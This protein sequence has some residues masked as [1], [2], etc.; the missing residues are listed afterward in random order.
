MDASF[1]G[2]LQIVVCTLGNPLAGQ[3][4]IAKTDGTDSPCGIAFQTYLTAWSIVTEQTACSLF[5]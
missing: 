4:L 5:F 3:L 2:S 1:F